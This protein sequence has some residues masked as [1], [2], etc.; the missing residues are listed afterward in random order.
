MS[1]NPQIATGLLVAGFE[2]ERNRKRLAEPDRQRRQRLADFQR[3]RPGFE[4][5]PFAARPPTKG[6]SVSRRRFGGHHRV[7]V[8]EQFQ[9]LGI[10]IEVPIRN[11]ID[12]TDC[13]ALPNECVALFDKIR[14]GTGPIFVG[15]TYNF[16]G[17]TSV[18]PAAS[19]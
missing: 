3:I 4:S 19:S 6:R 17:D 5:V 16:N 8:A 12:D 1:G 10:E 7:G 2:I 13:D 9:R 15:R 14:A 11:Q 18:R